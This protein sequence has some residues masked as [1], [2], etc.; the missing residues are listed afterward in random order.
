MEPRKTMKLLSK[1]APWFVAALLVGSQLYA[2]PVGPD[3]PATTAKPA[4]APLRRVSAAEAKQ[5]AQ[6]SRDKVRSDIQYIQHL[7][8]K[9]RKAKDVIKLTC[10]NDKF[11]KLKAEANLFDSAHSALI[12]VLDTEARHEAFDRV[13][14]SASRVHKIREE[15]QICV[16]ESDLSN[17]SSVEF[18]GPEIIDDPTLALPFDITVEPPAYA[19]PYI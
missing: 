10:V 6:A 14:A 18:T 4:P 15:A 13:S 19:S 2:Q 9:A 1:V 3:A 16:G 5:D 8:S 17:V 7:Q 12:A 11:I